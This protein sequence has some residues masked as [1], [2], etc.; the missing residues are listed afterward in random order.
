MASLVTCL[1][2][3]ARQQLVEC[4]N[5]AAAAGIRNKTVEREEWI[6]WHLATSRQSQ[7]GPWNNFIYT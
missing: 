4:R 7:Y 2:P 5:V 1:K 3:E 6:E